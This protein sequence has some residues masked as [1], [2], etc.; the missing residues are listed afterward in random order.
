VN[1]STTTLILTVAGIAVMIAIAY[2]QRRRKLLEYESWTSPIA[3]VRE[4]DRTYERL[5]AGD[6]GPPER[7]DRLKILYDDR[8]VRSVY[9]C[10]LFI[11]NR[12]NVAI[13]PADYIEPVTISIPRGETIFEAAVARVPETFAT[14]DASDEHVVLPARLLNPGET[15]RLSIVTTFGGPPEV[16]G[17]I[18][19]AVI[20]PVTEVSR[21]GCTVCG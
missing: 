10:A 12:G 21:L 18:V 16:T 13:P 8:E 7:I 5:S 14:I 2:F 4:P 17:G 11:R 20:R 9:H 19:G 15:I 1:Q 3:S 6:A